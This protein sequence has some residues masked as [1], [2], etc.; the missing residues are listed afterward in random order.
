MPVEEIKDGTKVQPNHVYIIPPNHNLAI[1]HG[2]L[3]LMPRAETRGQH[4]AVDYFFQSLA[5]DQR[6]G[7]IGII[8]SGTGADGTQGLEA[9]KAEGGLAIVQD[10]LSAKYDGMPHSA[11]TSGIVDLVLKPEQN[12]R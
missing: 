8:L 10:P 2:V 5:Q 1:L 6:S 11:I 7:A 12:R 4:M 9:I 3:S